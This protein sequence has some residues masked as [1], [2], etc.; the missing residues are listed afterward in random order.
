MGIRGA[1][2][3]THSISGVSIGELYQL[4]LSRKKAN[5]QTVHD[6]NDNLDYTP[7]IDIDASWVYRS[8]VISIENRMLWMIN[9]AIDLAK[10][11][12]IVVFVCDGSIRHHSKRAT[13]DR[14]SKLQKFIID[15]YLNRTELMRL[16]DKRQECTSIE[17]INIMVNRETILSKKIKNQEKNQQSSSIDVGDDF[18]NDISNAINDIDIKK[19][20][21]R[22]DCIFV[23]KAKFQADSVLAYRCINRISNVIFSSDSD[24]AALCGNCCV[25]I[26]T[27]KFNMKKNGERLSNMI[28]ILHH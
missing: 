13:I 3:Y 26:K 6:Q 16:A 18:F 14:K 5:N 8:S 27:F 11:G 17:E 25:G 15:G 12:F 23:I 1:H 10:T 7:T 20:A 19:N 4:A 2:T 28:Y 21:I 9:I 24:L 22:N